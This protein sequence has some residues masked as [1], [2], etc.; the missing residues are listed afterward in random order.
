MLAAV[1]GSSSRA[2]KPKPSCS[3]LLPKRSLFVLRDDLYL[4]HLH[5][6]AG[7]QSDSLDDLKKCV[8]W[9]EI[10]SR[11]S[12]WEMGDEDNDTKE[13]PR[14]RRV[15]LTIRAVEKIFKNPFGR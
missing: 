1:N 4:S 3:I 9:E 15:S 13:W 6:I 7:R 11:R 5:G 2:Y 12:R 10:S 14:G 8:N